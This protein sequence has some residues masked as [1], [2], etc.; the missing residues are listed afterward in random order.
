MFEELADST[1]RAHGVRLQRD[2][3]GKL[4]R[5]ARVTTS[6]AIQL[7]E[8]F[9]EGKTSR[10]TVLQAFQAAPVANL[11]FATVDTHRALRNG[12]PE[13]IFGAGKTPVQVVKI[14]AKLVE[15][16]GRVLVTRVTA[17]QAKAV[18]R[19]FK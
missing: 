10:E 15:K 17:E 16:D 6:E 14:A 18:R 9:R 19:Q 1:V 8:K 7:L 3:G 13:V 2:S 12:F 11:G 5:G 4:W